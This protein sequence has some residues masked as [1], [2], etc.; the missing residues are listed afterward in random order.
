M[1]DAMVPG[2]AVFEPEE[3]DVLAKACTLAGTTLKS[4][5]QND[6]TVAP[7]VA[8][9]V[10]N[11][12]RSRLRLKRRLATMSDAKVLAAE[13]VEL[14]HYLRD[15]GQ[16]SVEDS[17]LQPSPRVIPIFPAALRA[18]PDTILRSRSK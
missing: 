11:L 17:V 1:L 8:R 18:Q 5:I 7:E 10:H 6:P 13:A 15:K 14:F 3:V 2:A 9:L 4:E 12:G 16:D